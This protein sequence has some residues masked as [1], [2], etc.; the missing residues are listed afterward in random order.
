MPAICNADRDGWHEKSFLLATIVA[1]RR[2]GGY[3]ACCDLVH[4]A[5]P[6]DVELSGMLLDIGFS[7][8]QVDDRSRG[9]SCYQDGPLDLRMNFQAGLPAW[10]WLQ[11]ATI[12]E[13]MGL[14]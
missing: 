1:L 10:R 9:W 6:L 5:L 11:T 14:A 13:V 3:D 12:A 8:P 4:E 2:V 7:S